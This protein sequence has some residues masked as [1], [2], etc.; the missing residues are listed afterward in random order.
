MRDQERIKY[1]VV[2]LLVIGVLV[3][4]GYGIGKPSIEG[5]ARTPGKNPLPA[6]GVQ[7]VLC[8]VQEIEDRGSLVEVHCI[9]DGALT[10]VTDEEGK[11][12][13]SGLA[14]GKYVI[15]YQRFGTDFE[16]MVA[17]WDGKLFKHGNGDWY[18]EF[19]GELDQLMAE[20]IIIY[21]GD[22]PM[23]SFNLVRT[24][25]MGGLEGFPFMVAIEQDPFVPYIGAYVVEVV[26]GQTAQVEIEVYITLSGE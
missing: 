25:Y 16:Q 21:E 6:A 18:E 3:V 1:F 23:S 14:E 8:P 10:A 5:I 9:L 26:S 2:A 15:H 19:P 4:I 12:E 7:L 22:W 11:F 13:Y 24:A 17:E 20:L